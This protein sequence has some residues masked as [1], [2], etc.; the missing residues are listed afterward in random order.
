[1]THMF[2]RTIAAHADIRAFAKSCQQLDSLLRI[3]AREHL[4]LVASKERLSDC[5][6]KI[7]VF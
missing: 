6:S 7:L 2:V 4:F 1:M 3:R 5:C